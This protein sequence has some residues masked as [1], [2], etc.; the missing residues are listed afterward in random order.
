MQI[1]ITGLGVSEVVTA[2]INVVEKE[3]HALKDATFE[4]GGCGSHQVFIDLPNLEGSV[5]DVTTWESAR[6]VNV[7]I[8]PENIDEI[9]A[10]DRKDGF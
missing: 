7:V 1:N 9:E 4:Y 6:P 2:L 10:D 8:I 5:E 3:Q